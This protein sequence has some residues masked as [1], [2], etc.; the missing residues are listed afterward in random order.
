MKIVLQPLK[1]LAALGFAVSL[2]VYIAA[3]FGRNIISGRNLIILIG[4][5]G[6]LYA[7][8]FLITRWQTRDFKQKEMWKAALRGCP[9][10]MRFMVKA[11]G[12]YAVANFLLFALLSAKRGEPNGEVVPQTWWISTYGLSFYWTSFAMLYSS[13]HAGEADMRRRCVSGHLVPPLAK[14]CEECGAPLVQKAAQ[15]K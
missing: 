8:A 2:A 5:S 4:G 11:L 10:W 15:A 6:V 9:R 3:L 14:F 1:L 7:P 12:F 13:Q